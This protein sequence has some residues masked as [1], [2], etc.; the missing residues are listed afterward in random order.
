[1]IDS[2]AA[3]YMAYL[4]NLQP[5]IICTILD[6]LRRGAMSSDAVVVIFYSF[7]KVK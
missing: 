7:F 5:E 1:M 4:S 6:R 2:V 3:D